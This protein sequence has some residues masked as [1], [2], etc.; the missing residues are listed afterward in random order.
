[1]VTGVEQSLTARLADTLMELTENQLRMVASVVQALGVPVEFYQ[2]SNSDLVDDQFAEIVSNFLALH[3]ALHEE[4]FSKRP[5]EYLLKQCLIAQGHQ[6]RLNPSPGDSTFDVEGAGFR[7]S[8]KTEAALGISKAQVKVEKLMEARWVREC[9]AP[10][11][12]AKE[13][14]TRLP[15]HMDGYDRILVLRAFSQADSTIYKLEEIPKG[16]LV[17]TLSAA[18]PGMFEKKGKAKSFGADFY[19]HNEST[20]AF[21]ILLDSSVEKIRL[22]FSTKHCIHHGT[23]VVP[24]AD[25]QTLQLYTNRS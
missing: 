1:M 15:R 20:K 12:C 18:S 9:Q 21:R 19:W 4:S 14:R 16:L 13:V 17:E 24:K 6:A 2:E 22:W 23:W 25:G 7:W 8:L 3:H 5:F 10:E 11:E